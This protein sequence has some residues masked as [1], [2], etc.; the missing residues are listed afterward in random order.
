M[1]EIVHAGSG[2]NIE[3]FQSSFL[4]VLGSRNFAVLSFEPVTVPS[5][6]EKLSSVRN[7]D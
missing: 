6:Y 7:S 1:R 3:A 4:S 2:F 5:L